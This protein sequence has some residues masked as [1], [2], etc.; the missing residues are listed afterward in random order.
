MQNKLDLFQ[1]IEQVI[2][3]GDLNLQRILDT[4]IVRYTETF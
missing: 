2:G 3:G 1:I 4:E